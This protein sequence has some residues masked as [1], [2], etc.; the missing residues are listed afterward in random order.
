MAHTG[1]F[2]I[3]ISSVI[4]R[5][6]VDDKGVFLYPL[7]GFQEISQITKIEYDV[8]LAGAYNSRQTPV[9]WAMIHC[10]N[11]KMTQ[12]QDALDKEFEEEKHNILAYG[13]DSNKGTRDSCQINY[14]GDTIVLQCKTHNVALPVFVSL[15]LVIHIKK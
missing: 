6:S 11:G 7:L 9:Y 8:Y 1:V 13:W 10:A 12:E 3:N 2:D 4:H 15:K 5:H 14:K